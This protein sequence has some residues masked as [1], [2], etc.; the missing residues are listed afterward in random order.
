MTALPQ[1]VP[2]EDGH[3]RDFTTVNVVTTSH[4]SVD[5]NDPAVLGEPV[6]YTVRVDEF[7]TPEVLTAALTY[8]PSNCECEHS[9]LFRHK[10]YFDFTT[11][12][13]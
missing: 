2:A 8:L 9:E 11:F 4:F 1:E 3:P 13:A 7:Y 5:R 6:W 12:A 10:W